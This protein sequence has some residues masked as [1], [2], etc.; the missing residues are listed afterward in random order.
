MSE[1]ADDPSK[2]FDRLVPLKLSRHSSMIG[3]TAE[4]AEALLYRWPEGKGGAKHLAARRACL[5]ALKG[6][7]QARKARE[8][9]EA[10]AREADILGE[11]LLDALAR[12]SKR[13]PNG[14]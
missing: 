4:A 11:T 9:L 3:T 5:R 2:P 13:K 7:I 1:I 14:R 6:E 10:A 12:H 8:A